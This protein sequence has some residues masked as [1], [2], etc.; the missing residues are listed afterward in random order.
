M[1]AQ[2]YNPFAKREQ[3]GRTNLIVYKV[4]TIV[5][6]LFVVITG[7]Y[8]TFNK[9]HE[10]RHHHINHTIWGQ[11]DHRRTSFSLNSVVISIYWVVTLVLQAHYVRYLWDAD[12]SYKTSAANVGS[13][14]IL[15]NTLT[16]G[17]IMLWVRGHFWLGEILLAINLFNLV[18]LYFRHSSYPRLIHIPIV[19]AP[20]AW[21]YVAMLWDGAA[22]V[23]A[24][25]LPARV[26]GN[27]IIWGLLAIGGFYLLVFKDYSMGFELAILSL[28]IALGQLGTKALAIQ[29]VFAFVIMGLLLIGSVVIAV[30]SVIGQRKEDLPQVVDEDRERAP[31][32]DDH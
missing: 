31:L 2:D 7:A 27:I 26:A 5:S 21:T 1:P 29:W 11:N 20:L 3:F 19:S 23:N 13:H 25:N 18:L 15:H 28:A 9:P 32:L 6:W 22:A 14:F 4:L 24:H 17:F 12:E 16:F 10:H 30:P 8:Y